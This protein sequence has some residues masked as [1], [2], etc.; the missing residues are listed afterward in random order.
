MSQADQPGRRDSN[1]SETPTQA[2]MR[3]AASTVV[4][5]VD[6]VSRP[7]VMP[8]SAVELA[9]ESLIAGGHVLL[10]DVPGTGKT[11]LARAIAK[12]SSGTTSRIQLVADLL[13]S[14]LTGIGVFDQQT[15][16]FVFR[17]GPIFANVVIADEINRASPKT[18]SALLEAMGEGRVS[19]DGATH[20]LPDPFL[21][22]ATENAVEMQG[23]YP[24]S[25]AQLDRFACRISIGYPSAAD[26]ASMLLAPIGYDPVAHVSQACELEEL[27]QARSTCARVY[28][29]PKVADYVVRILAATRGAPNVALGASP[30]A[31]LALLA[32]ARAH[33]LLDGRPAVFPEDVRE[34]AVPVLSH[35]LILTDD[36]RGQKAAEQIV[37]ELLTSIRPPRG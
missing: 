26:E 20:A 22:I 28:V 15:G 2:E 10:E 13:P 24:L 3:A 8:S 14:D 31:G 34:L 19:V 1:T 32:L 30:R 25:E 33:A 35:R 29:S 36:Q 17:P 4:A 23:T 37:A 9:V 7:L 6:S 16:V 18:Q 27:R 21:V 12:A 11:T 5:L